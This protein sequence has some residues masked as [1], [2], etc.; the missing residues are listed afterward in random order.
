MPLAE[1]LAVVQ[2]L[3]AA[4]CRFWV[5]GGWGVDAL[6]G[7]V[8]RA[9]RDLD[10]AVDAAVEDRAVRVLGQRG[11]TVQTDWRP[12]RVELVAAPAVGWVG[13]HPVVFDEGGY[14]RQ[15][16]LDG[17]CFGYP[18]DAFSTGRLGGAEV[19][20]L[21]REQQLRFHRGYSPRAVDLHD[22]RLLD[23]GGP[24]WPG[25]LFIVVGLPGAGKTTLARSLAGRHRAVRLHADEW[26]DRPGCQSVRFGGT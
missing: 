20:C 2:A 14:G 3:E 18:P 5:A 17:G 15:A 16:D 11:Y 21:S 25:R 1:V 22:L 6:L 10:L 7:R 9:H 13:L 19:P 8:T 23:Q 4:G 24:T 12:V 26:A